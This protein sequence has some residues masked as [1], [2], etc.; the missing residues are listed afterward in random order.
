M[1]NR[2]TPEDADLVAQRVVARLVRVI[3]AIAVTLLALWILPLL[4][5]YSFRSAS[6]EGFAWPSIVI[7]LA[8]VVVVVVIVRFWSRTMRGTNR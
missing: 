2:M 7:G 5:L 8:A 3:G 6:P 1:A 4:L